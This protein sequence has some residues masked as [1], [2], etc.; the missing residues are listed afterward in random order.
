MTDAQNPNSDQGSTPNDPTQVHNFSDLNPTDR[1]ATAEHP[2]VPQDATAAIPIVDPVVAP[3]IE[4]AADPYAANPALHTPQV[5]N[6][7]IAT[8]VPNDNPKKNLTA[9][10]II[11]AIVAAIA[12]GL[13]AAAF[14]SNNKNAPIAPV[15]QTPTITPTQVPTTP[16]FVP[17]T[18]TY[19]PTTPT[20]E[21][22]TPSPTP[23]PTKS[24]ADKNTS[25]NFQN[26]GRANSAP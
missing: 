19:A 3:K 24:S 23:T 7:P 21:P 14:M 16:T 4:P 8:Q 5:A 25:D 1:D 11:L 6:S 17:T 10:W 2:A 15:T 20:Y 9:L 18:P 12:V 13:G 22:T 26:G